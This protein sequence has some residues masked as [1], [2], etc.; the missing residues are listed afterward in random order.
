MLWELMVKKEVVS[1]PY[2][3][4][5]IVH[6]G[7]FINAGTNLCEGAISPQIYFMYWDQCCKGLSC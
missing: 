4:H 2:G 1:I 5:V 7:D 3:K 6:E